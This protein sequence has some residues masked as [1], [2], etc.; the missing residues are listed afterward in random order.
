MIFPEGSG[1]NGKNIADEN[2][3]VGSLSPGIYTINSTTRQ[4]EDSH[5]YFADNAAVVQ[6]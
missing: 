2:A 5:K 1:R 6:G 3:T 4:R